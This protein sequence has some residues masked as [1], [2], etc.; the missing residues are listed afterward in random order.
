MGKCVNRR[1]VKAAIHDEEPGK[2]FEFCEMNI[3]KKYTNDE[4][5][6][7]Y[8]SEFSKL[9]KYQADISFAHIDYTFLKL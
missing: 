5:I 4:T 2:D 1:H 3:E 8:N 9:K 6:R 7:S